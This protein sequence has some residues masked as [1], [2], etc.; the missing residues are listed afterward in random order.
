MRL[1]GQFGGRMTQPRWPWVLAGVLMGSAGLA[2]AT[3]SGQWTA[4]DSG[5]TATLR[6]VAWNGLE[7]VAVGDAGTILTSPDGVKWTAQ[8]SP[9]KEELDAVGLFRETW[10]AVG[11]NGTILTSQNGTEW[12]AQNSRTKAP[13]RSVAANKELIIAAGTGSSIRVSD[14]GRN[15]R[16][17]VVDLP[18]A[19]DFKMVVG[20][21]TGFTIYSG[22]GYVSYRLKEKQ[23]EWD[24]SHLQPAAAGRFGWLFPG[25]STLLKRGQKPPAPLPPVN[26]LMAFPQGGGI[27]VGDDGRLWREGMFKG[28]VWSGIKDETADSLFAGWWSGQHAVLV[29]ARGAIL[30]STDGVIWN[31]HRGPAGANLRA[32]TGSEKLVVMVGEN[33]TIL[34]GPNLPS[35]DKP[36]VN[37][38]G[39]AFAELPE[40]R[41]RCPIAGAQIHYTLDDSTPTAESPVYAQPFTLSMSGNLRA[42]AFK[43]GLDPS[44]E[45]RAEFIH[46]APPVF[47][48]PLQSVRIPVNEE[49]DFEATAEGIGLFTTPAWYLKPLQGNEQGVPS[50][51]IDDRTSIVNLGL[52][53][54][55]MNGSVIR[56]M[57]TNN[58]GSV[59]EEATLTVFVPKPVLIVTQPFSQ[60]VAER[61]SVLF[62]VETQSDPKPSCQWERLTFVNRI[63]VW[64]KIEDS[65]VFSG[66]KTNTLTIAAP[67]PEM[68]GESF[69][70]KITDNYFKDTSNKP[71]VTD[72]IDVTLT[73]DAP[74][75]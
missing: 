7:F 74:P 63:A 36:I 48:M 27:I 30:S 17:P 57:A 9:V 51:R 11:G 43:E 60:T 14:D 23:M 37:P 56:C 6:G 3:D 67:T 52:A 31:A 53:A 61:Q 16:A 47:R 15:W 8:K 24:P 75:H 40:V 19:L 42:R 71:K 49:V 22:Q 28:N 18:A 50:L 44:E 38:D 34:T 1:L 32:I 4:Q 29:G 12:L 62:K 41:L 55:S 72:T 20:T 70:C 13:L 68:S 35:V 26:W 64:E 59:S 45:V 65:A 2:A 58:Y 73:V 69:R 66:T 54:M 33:G 10:V 39:G 25:T 46:M 5:T 21:G